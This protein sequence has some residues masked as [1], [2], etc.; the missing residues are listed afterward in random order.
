MKTAKSKSSN[1]KSH[2]LFEHPIIR[3][4]VVANLRRVTDLQI[5]N[6][7]T[8]RT[9]WIKRLNQE[10]PQKDIDAECGYPPELDSDDYWDMFAREGIAAKVI[11]IYPKEAWQMPPDV[12]ETEDNEKTTEFETA[13]E[14]L[15]ER[16]SIIPK[17]QAVD[18]WA[19]IGRYGVLVLGFNDGRALSEPVTASKGL[20]LLYVRPLPEKF[21]TILS[22]ESDVQ[23]PRYAQPT[24]YD[25]TFVNLKEG[26][27]VQ[28]VDV[29]TLTPIKVHWTRIV[30]ISDDGEVLHIP[31]LQQSFNRAY[32]L[33]KILG[34]DGEAVWKG[35]FPGIAFESQ[36]GSDPIEF[37]ED[38]QKKMK[39]EIEKY[40]MGLQ[41]Y[42]TL[43]GL[44]AK[45]LPPNVVDPKN[46]FEVQMAAIALTIDVPLRVFLGSEE[47][48]LASSQDQR[49]WN[50]R[51]RNR[52]IN[53]INPYIIRP[54]FNRMFDLGILPRPKKIIIDW[55]DLNAPTENDRAITSQ[56]I[57]DAL[58]KYVAGKVY[59]MIPP[60]EYMTLILGLTLG[61]ADA[62]IKAAGGSKKM[63]AALEKSNKPPM[64]PGGKAPNASS[65]AGAGAA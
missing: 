59:L 28:S 40:Q 65:S 38:M 24:A 22:F 53:N 35:G 33:R 50:K 47:G 54:F 9:E 37:D 2:D 27:T 20:E 11:T 15:N 42:L 48:K 39:E 25:I 49:T 19:G 34:A 7:S 45:T 29:K 51:L 32:D 57:T 21:A 5:N 60:R 55:P 63:I 17:L 18:K 4:A 36:A 43:L 16:C 31:R 61:Q 56:K 64:K 23:S 13:W 62:I 30:H 3:D 8:M 41:R 14:E 52:Q 44:T 12:Y 10:L 6:L 58:Q 26:E 46:H 1:G